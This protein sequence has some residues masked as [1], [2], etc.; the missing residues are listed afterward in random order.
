MI[1]INGTVVNDKTFPNGELQ[2]DESFIQNTNSI[3]GINIDFH[4][5]SNKDLMDLM[6][7]VSYVYDQTDI[8]PI[9][10]MTYMPYSRM[11]RQKTGKAFLEKPRKSAFTL[12]YISDIINTLP[13]QK[14]VIFE[15]HSDV[16]CAL[17]NNV[18]IK[19]P[20]IDLLRMAKGDNKYDKAKDIIFYPDAGAQ[21]RYTD[22]FKN[23]NV[24]GFKHRNWETGQIESL[25][26]CGKLP[27]KGFNAYIVDDLCSFGGTFILAA[28]KLKELG[29]NKIFLIVGHCENSILKGKIPESDL[30]TTVY[31]TN[32]IFTGKL[33]KIKVINCE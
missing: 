21:K 28:E 5:E 30:I 8:K 6:L 17:L 4:F 13:L 19:Y 16:C 12:K 32:S 25:E 15:P 33:D 7:I 27:E 18:E 10:N 11:D 1:K 23:P 31:T 3:G 2:I 26:V 9:L 20:T 24:V 22:L 14:I 29:A